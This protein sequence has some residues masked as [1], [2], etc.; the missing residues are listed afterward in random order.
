MTDGKSTA[1]DEKV[2]A[3]GG[4]PTS[5]KKA[6]DTAEAYEQMSGLE[7]Q[8]V[9]DFDPV[10]DSINAALEDQ[11]QPELEEPAYINA[12][13]EEREQVEYVDTSGDDDDSDEDA[14]EKPAAKKT[15]AKKS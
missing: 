12:E 7:D 11:D 5:D 4:S 1:A 3:G 6:A 10:M 15:A 13:Y 9:Q 14:D 8:P 2:A